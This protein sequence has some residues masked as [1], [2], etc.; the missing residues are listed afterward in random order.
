[1]SKEHL[2]KYLNDHLAGAVAALEM[3][4]HLAA[5]TSSARSLLMELKADIEKDKK[6][7]VDL[8]DQLGV[9]QSLVR[10]AAA[11]VGEQV[12]ETKL[13]MDDQSTGALRALERLEILSLGIEGKLGLWRALQAAGN[14]ELKLTDV[15]YDRLMQRAREQRDKVE[16]LRLEA[17]RIALARAA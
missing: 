13:T 2:S 16:S 5:D 7:L 4:D 10:K 11:W 6:E 9:G 3:I 14:R 15:D 17:A 12:A 8:M 1:M